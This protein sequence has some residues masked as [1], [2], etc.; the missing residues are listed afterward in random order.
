MSVF[1]S[2]EE[3]N[4]S[5]SKNEEYYRMSSKKINADFSG[6]WILLV[7]SKIN[8]RI[9]R[10]GELIRAIH[11]ISEKMFIDELQFLGGK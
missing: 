9:I 2:L 1:V 6:K 10:Y 3:K 7:V 4:N 5:L 8:H 11:G